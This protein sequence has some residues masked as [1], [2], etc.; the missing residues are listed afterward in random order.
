MSDYY[1]DEYNF[2]VLFKFAI[3][4]RETGL[5]KKIPKTN[6]FDMNYVIPQNK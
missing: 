3:K 1:D 6:Y 4:A 2:M 5:R